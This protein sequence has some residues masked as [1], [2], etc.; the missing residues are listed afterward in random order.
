MFCVLCSGAKKMYDFMCELKDI[1]NDS[2][3]MQKNNFIKN[4][5]IFK[6]LTNFQQK[7]TLKAQMH[8]IM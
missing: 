3:I 4:H 6:I 1:C 2:R 5:A 7:P 8:E